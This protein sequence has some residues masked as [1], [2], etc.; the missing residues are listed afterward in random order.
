MSPLITV[1]N[2]TMGLNKYLGSALCILQNEVIT[3]LGKAAP[4]WRNKSVAIVA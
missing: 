4:L 1:Q 3:L 2:L